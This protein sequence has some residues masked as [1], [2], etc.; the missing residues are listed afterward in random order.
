MIRTLALNINNYGDLSIDRNWRTLLE[1]TAN[2]LQHG[3]AK[4]K[5]RFS[6]EQ[7]S[8]EVEPHSLD[9]LIRFIYEAEARAN[10]KQRVFVKENHT[11]TFLS[12]LLSHFPDSRYLFMV[13]DPRDMAL[14]WKRAASAHGAVKAGARQWL[15]DQRRSLEVY[16]FLKDLGK[17]ILIKFETLIGDPQQT[18]RQICDFLGIEFSPQM[19]EFHRKEI[20]GENAGRMSSWKDL[21]QPIIMDNIDLYK[22][23]LSETEIRFVE[24]LCREEMAFF[25]YRPQFDDSVPIEELEG[26]LPEELSHRD[27]SK[28]TDRERELFP[29]FDAARQRIIERRL[30]KGLS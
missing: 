3:I 30:Q 14:T 5:V 27:E 4:W 19:L 13:R 8:R 15:E 16:G 2:L 28:L 22:K 18:A 9:A 21:Q 7:L 24:T 1:D 20:V 25:G 26:S 11:Y 10:G 29:A 17:I 12:Y 6:A 23:N